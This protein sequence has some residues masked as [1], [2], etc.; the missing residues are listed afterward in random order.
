[1]NRRAGRREASS[2]SRSRMVPLASMSS[3]PQSIWKRR[4]AQTSQSRLL[5]VRLCWPHTLGRKPWLPRRALS[6]LPHLSP[7]Q[8]ALLRHLPAAPEIR[9]RW[10]GA[11][12][13]SFYVQAGGSAGA[14]SASAQRPPTP[15]R[16]LT[17]RRRPLGRD[18]VCWCWHHPC[19]ED[20][21]LEDIRQSVTPQDHGPS[22]LFLSFACR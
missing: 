21:H 8:P 5:S 16:P 22:H 18:G 4:A 20:V 12:Q 14:N 11:E 10:E 2:S 1:M 3:L 15:R 6:S 9:Q 7:C 13:V 17:W 19:C